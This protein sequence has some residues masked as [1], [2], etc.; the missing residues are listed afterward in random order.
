MRAHGALRRRWPRLGS[1]TSL[2]RPRRHPCC[3]PPAA[4][5]V[6]TEARLAE[7]G[8]VLPP[9]P[10]PRGNY[11]FCSR[12]GPHV[13][14]I[15]IPARPDGSLVAGSVGD[16]LSAEEGAAAARLAAINLL[17]TLKG[18]LGDLDRARLVKVTGYVNCVDGFEE[19]PVVMNGFSDLMV[20]ALGDERGVH[21]RAAVG[22]RA[23]PLGM[24]VEIEALIEVLDG[25]G[26]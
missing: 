19:H 24:C 15:G 3:P 23:L 17:A 18:E 22:T 14:G 8:V 21:C 11:V 5:R 25:G 20:D 13:H 6:H 7:L 10:V 12:A 4:R 9:P 26:T 2:G 1:S 16:Q